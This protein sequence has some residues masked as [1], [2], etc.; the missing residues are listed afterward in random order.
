MQNEETKYS[1]STLTPEDFDNSA[2]WQIDNLDKLMTEI[3]SNPEGV[4]S[5]ILDIRK[6]YIEYFEQANEAD[7][8]YNKI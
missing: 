5:M 7:K 6:T 2:A 8:Q 1:R 4:L 3:D